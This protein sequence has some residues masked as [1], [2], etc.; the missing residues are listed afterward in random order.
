MTRMIRYDPVY[1]VLRPMDSVFDDIHAPVRAL[2]TPLAY[3]ETVTPVE[4][5]GN[6]PLDV[7]E[8]DDEL[9]VKASLPGFRED[10]I[11]IEEHQG[12]LTIRAERKEERKEEGENWLVQERR[13]HVLER[14]IPLPVEVKA[15]KAK[16][17]LQNGILQIVFPKVAEGKGITNRIKVSVPKLKLPKL[18]KKEGK[19]K[20]KKG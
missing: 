2:G 14:S 19:V 5:V 15:E 13:V 4:T 9:V 20:V 6:L 3:A 7:Y 1:D 17:V 10:E 18:G 12:I 11:E 16:A 8:T